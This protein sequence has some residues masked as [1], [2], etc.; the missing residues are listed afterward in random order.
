MRVQTADKNI[1]VIHI[2]PVHQLTSC[3]FDLLFRTRRDGKFHPP[4]GSEG[5]PVS[6][7]NVGQCGVNLCNLVIC[8]NGGTCVDSGSSVY[9]QCV[10]GWK[11]ALCSEKVSFCDAEHIPPPSCARGA[12]CVPLP[13][14]YTCQCPLGSAGLFCQ[15]GIQ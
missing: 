13:D 3:I 14:G 6:G 11:G 5:R 2:T 9:C 12:T 10:L 1:T 4:G 7:R 15:Q 8:K